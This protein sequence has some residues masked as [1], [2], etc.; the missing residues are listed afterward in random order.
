MYRILRTLTG[1]GYVEQLP[2]GRFI[3]YLTAVTNPGQQ[4]RLGAADVS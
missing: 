4:P 3:G 2:D 1:A